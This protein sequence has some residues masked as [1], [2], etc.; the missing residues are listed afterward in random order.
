[1]PFSLHASIGLSNDKHRDNEAGV[2]LK[3]KAAPP[4]EPPV[5][6]ARPLGEFPLKSSL[7]FFSHLISNPCLSNAR[8][9]FILRND[10]FPAQWTFL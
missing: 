1:M 8:K 4:G 3:S 10:K 5:G 9:A 7:P 6:T 2:Y